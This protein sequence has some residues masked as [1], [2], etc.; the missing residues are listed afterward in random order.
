[1]FC[2]YKMSNEQLAGGYDP[3]AGSYG[4]RD[5]EC[6]QNGCQLWNERFGMCSRAV[7]AYLK[8]NEDWRRE[9]AAEK[10]GRE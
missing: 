3:A 1:M 8:G 5:W 6:E 10:A 9:S 4:E 7:D 2:P